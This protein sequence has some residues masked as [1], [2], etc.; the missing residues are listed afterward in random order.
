MAFVEGAPSAGYIV[1]WS[2]TVKIRGGHAR[3][4]RNRYIVVTVSVPTDVSLAYCVALVT[5]KHMTI[6]RLLATWKKKTF[7]WYR[8][9]PMA[10]WL[11]ILQLHF[12]LLPGNQHNE[13][14]LRLG[15][16][17][18][19]SDILDQAYLFCPVVIYETLE[20]NIK[21]VIIYRHNSDPCKWA[22]CWF[23]RICILALFFAVD[24]SLFTF[25]NIMDKTIRNCASHVLS[26][27]WSWHTEGT[28]FAAK[29]LLK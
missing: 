5:C 29:S 26:E 15:S 2:L 16:H 14:R 21:T 19:S 28:T 22:L 23:P 7:L 18:K 12:R 6:W 9:S 17:V 11:D 27:S 1:V 25:E 20:S 4:V 8:C 3:C 24:E 13:W 10:S